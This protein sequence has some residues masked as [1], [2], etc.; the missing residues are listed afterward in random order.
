MQRDVKRKGRFP[1]G[2]PKASQTR[3][4]ATILRIFLLLCLLA[5]SICSFPGGQ[6]L[7]SAAPATPVPASGAPA[8]PA[9][10]PGAPATPLTVIVQVPKAPDNTEGKL[11]KVAGFDAESGAFTLE[12]AFADVLG[13][14]DLLDNPPKVLDSEE[15]KAKY[16]KDLQDKG[17][18]LL[19]R[20]TQN[21]IN[22]SNS[23]KTKKNAGG[24]GELSFP[25]QGKTLDPALYILVIAPYINGKM[26]YTPQINMFTIPAKDPQNTSQWLR[27]LI[28]TA[29]VEEKPN[30][31]GITVIKLW[32]D[33]CGKV[34][35][36]MEQL[37]DKE[38]NKISV[39]YPDKITAIL[40]QDGKEYKRAELSAA[41][42]WQ[43]VFKDL[44]V[45]HRYVV[46]EV[47]NSAYKLLVT[48]EGQKVVL[49]NR[50][51]PGTPPCPPPTSPPGTPPAPPEKLPFTAVLWW[52]VYLCG[53][54]GL[55]LICLGLLRRKHR[56]R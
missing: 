10:A 30:T 46:G 49:H 18:T 55:A 12:P 43:Y 16:K 11:Y 56:E 36:T 54:V 24:D 45:G 1:V 28:I 19:S 17:Q 51:K 53:A 26:A 23:A 52:P 29:K 9:P 44:S 20:I 31:E 2:A 32:E 48:V 14:K 34:L 35:N 4:V 15:I 6:R 47:K 50:L 38:K 21:N 25:E 41:N 22:P 7:V 33:E 8:A 37:N 13:L 3:R 5:G 39:K 40:Y 42:N 27:Q